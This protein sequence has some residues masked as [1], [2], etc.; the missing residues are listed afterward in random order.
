MIL[1]DLKDGQGLGNQLWLMATAIYLSNQKS[2]KLIIRNIKKFKAKDLLTEK[3]FFGIELFSEEHLKINWKVFS[4]RGFKNIK[5]NTNIYFQESKKFSDLVDMFEYVQIEGNFQSSTIIPSPEDLRNFFNYND[6]FFKPQ[7]DIEKICL[8]NIR[9]GAY[10]G[11]FKSPCVS[12]DYI[13]SCISIFNERYPKIDFKII[14][15]DYEYARTILPEYEILYGNIKEDYLHINFA[16]FL[17]LSNSSF[18]YFPTY[19]SNNKELILAPY[20]WGASNSSN[21]CKEWISPCNFT[22]SFVYVNNK[23]NLIKDFSYFKAVFDSS[24]NILPHSNS[25]LF[26]KMYKSVEDYPT[27]NKRKIE[28]NNF[29]YKRNI[30]LFIWILRRYIFLIKKYYLSFFN[31]ISL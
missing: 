8:I 19:L 13:Y 2:R 24:E 20:K 28:R 9:G 27:I 25:L 4:P 1:I 11:M 6:N 17:I 22:N 10:L 26:S 29:F 30:T 3:F 12:L 14:T 23:G 31:Q 7:F 21:K 15:D 18:A 16:K 5:K